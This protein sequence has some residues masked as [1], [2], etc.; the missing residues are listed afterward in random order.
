MLEVA[1]FSPFELPELA[2]ASHQQAMSDWLENWE[3]S[4]AEK[5]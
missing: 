2:F 5:L 4:K 1:A 3:E